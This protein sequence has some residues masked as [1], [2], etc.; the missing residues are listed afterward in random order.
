MNVKVAVGLVFNDKGEILIAQRPLHNE[1]GGCW[2]FPGGK[3]E[4]EEE[5]LDALKRELWEE[6]GITVHQA[7]PF[8]Q[9]QFNYGSKH[10]LLDVWRVTE[11][12]GKAYAKETQPAL[13]WVAVTQL[14]QFVFPAANQ[15]IVD[16][17]LSFAI[18]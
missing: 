10:V 6:V 16:K 3:C 15:D 12:S 14:P 1:H 2:E 17:L 4:A 13:Q 8:M 5:M 11:F 18:H 7:Q 9:T